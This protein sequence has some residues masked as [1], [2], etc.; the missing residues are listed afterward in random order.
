ML[1]SAPCAHPSGGTASA[2]ADDG[3]ISVQA[4]QCAWASSTV[5]PRRRSWSHEGAWPT[6]GDVRQ[7]GAAGDLTSG[8]PEQD[9]VIRADGRN[10]GPQESGTDLRHRELVS[11]VPRD[12][13]GSALT[14]GV[15]DGG[16]R[17]ADVLAETHRKVG[18]LETVAVDPDLKAE[19]DE[20]AEQ[21]NNR[22]S[23]GRAVAE[24]PHSRPRRHDR[25]RRDR[26]M[27][28]VKCN[29]VNATYRDVF[30]M[31]QSGGRTSGRDLERSAP[32][33][34]AE[35]FQLNPCLA[36]AGEAATKSTSMYAV[37]ASTTTFAEPGRVSRTGRG[38]VPPPR[39]LDHTGCPSDAQ[40]C[41]VRGNRVEMGL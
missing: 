10:I 5:R 15:V 6:S 40:S 36:A 32:S 27:S 3:E 29:F 4:R 22:R 8:G 33:G 35:R 39:A 11:E 1:R 18:D 31:M 17:P 28:K 9:L 23:R 12:W 38:P 14:H 21:V 7:F 13:R 41:R 26:P 25:R 24:L 20:F 19:I 34:T 37:L 30:D 16:C 2:I